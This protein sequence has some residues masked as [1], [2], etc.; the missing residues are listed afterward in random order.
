MFLREYQ[1]SD[2][3]AITKVYRDAV[4]GIGSTVYNSEQI[5]VW[6]SYPDELEYFREL[7]SLG[8]T[9][10]ASK[11]QEIVA[12]GQL[13]PVNHLAF[14]YTATN[15]SYQGIATAIYQKL[16]TEAKQKQ[17]KCLYTEASRI[18]KFFFLKHGFNIVETEIALRC[19]VE[20]ERF[21]MQK[22]IR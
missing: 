7:L 5:K 4:I 12:F 9:I 3:E 10:V 1:K 11:N 20:F 17:V 18:A 14:I 2:A 13:N 21:K 16:E 22:L 8:L 15:Y 6:S 19:G